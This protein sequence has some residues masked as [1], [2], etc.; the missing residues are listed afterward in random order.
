MSKKYSFSAVTQ[1]VKFLKNS[2]RRLATA[3]S[4]AVSAAADDARGRNK[5]CTRICRQIGK[6]HDP[7]VERRLS[8]VKKT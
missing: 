1:K 2:T 5:I 8:E 3:A 7:E 4:S 6:S